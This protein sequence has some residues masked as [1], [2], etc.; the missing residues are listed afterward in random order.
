MGF[1]QHNN[2]SYYI[3][4]KKNRDWFH[5]LRRQVRD[6]QNGEENRVDRRVIYRTYVRNNISEDAFRVE[7]NSYS[8]R[9]DVYIQD[10]TGETE[11]M[12]RYRERTP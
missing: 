12:R 1:N 8:R 9:L 5:T 11:G 4:I 10:D 2:Y 6:Q 7:P 3:E